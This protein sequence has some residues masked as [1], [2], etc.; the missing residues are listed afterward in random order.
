MY[1]RLREL[2]LS[3]AN[4]K[5]YPGWPFPM[6]IH[7]KEITGDVFLLDPVLEF[8]VLEL[9]RNRVG[10]GDVLR[11]GFTDSVGHRLCA[12]A[13]SEAHV[14]MGRSIEGRGEA[15]GQGRWQL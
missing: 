15:I 10:E 9:G 2:C 11:I 4:Q 7:G 8:G 12:A 14:F 5:E 6:L 1:A 13:H 3:E